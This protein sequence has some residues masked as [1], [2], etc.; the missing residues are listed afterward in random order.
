MVI[1]LRP[2]DNA[3]AILEK[4]SEF[5]A[6]RGMNVSE[7]K[8]KITAATDGFNFLGWFF[9]VQRN[10][11]FRCVPSEDNY[12]AFRK[13]VKHIVNNSNYGAKTKAEKLAP[14][15]RGWRQY[16]KYCKMDG[17][18]NSLYFIQ[19][20][21]F[22]VFNLFGCNSPPLAAALSRMLV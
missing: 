12:K 18:R 4:I 9:K 1:I 8:T 11:K 3:E 17:S 2:Q 22:T 19:K 7:K 10:G 16:H 21:A 20:R 6:K 5:L 13:K 15:V 14:L